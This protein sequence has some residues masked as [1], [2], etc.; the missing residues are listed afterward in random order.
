MEM[1]VPSGTMCQLDKTSLT[2]TPLTWYTAQT[3][4]VSAD[5][6]EDAVVDDAV[7]LT[8]AVSGGD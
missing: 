3:V 1:S 4:A 7:R 8:H 5:E 6:D 2:F